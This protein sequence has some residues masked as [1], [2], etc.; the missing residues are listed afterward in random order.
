MR[1]AEGHN[2]VPK[3]EKDSMFRDPRLRGGSSPSDN[4]IVMVLVCPKA[5]AMRHASGNKAARQFQTIR[6][7]L[8]I[9]TRSGLGAVPSPFVTQ[10]DGSLGQGPVEGGL[11]LL[12]MNLF[13]QTPCPVLGA[14]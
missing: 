6:S 10:S 12:R 8:N 1:I 5:P 9:S 11:W 3:V 4:T 14:D 2:L 13:Y 7:F